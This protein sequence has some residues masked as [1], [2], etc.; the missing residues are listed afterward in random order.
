MPSKSKDQFIFNSWDIHRLTSIKKDIS[1]AGEGLRHGV[2]VL[3]K[4][5]IVLITACWEAY[6]EDVCEECFDFFLQ[7]CNEPNNFPVN[8]RVAASQKLSSDSDKRKIWQLAGDGWKT[9][10]KQN[11]ENVIRKFTGNFNTPNPDNIDN[12]FE[13]VIGKKNISSIWKWKGMS[14]KQA[15]NKL[16]KYLEIRGSIVHRTRHTNKI[17]SA[18]VEN[19]LSFI[20][21]LVIITDNG[22]RNYTKK[23]I[24]QYPW[25]ET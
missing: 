23:I 3:N 6:I 18:M 2:E 5:G 8:A 22:L 14:V 13:I 1:G 10:M 12:L 4:S 15:K 17:T 21:R 24:N 16:R 20:E 19:Y 11:K 9:V 25:M 7:K